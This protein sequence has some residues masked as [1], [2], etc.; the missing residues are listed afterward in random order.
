MALEDMSFTQ[1]MLIFG[2]LSMMIIVGWNLAFPP[3]VP[4]EGANQDAVAVAEDS[5]ATETASA[6]DQKPAKA[7]RAEAASAGEAA[8][9]A[10]PF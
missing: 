6:E 10:R 1:R 3:P 2:S 8:A 4:E 7:A 5:E 9:P